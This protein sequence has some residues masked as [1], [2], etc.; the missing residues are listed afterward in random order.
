MATVADGG[1]RRERRRHAERPRRALRAAAS[2][3][4]RPAGASAASAHDGK[5]NFSGVW[6]ALNEA[7]WDLRGARSAPGNGDADR[8]STIT[9]TPAFRRRPSSRSVPR[10][11]FRRRLAS[12]R[13]TDRFRTSQKRR[14]QRR[15]TAST[16][17]I[18]IPNSSATCPALRGRCTAVSVRD[19]PGHQQGADDLRV[20]ERGAAI[21]LE[22]GRRSARGY[23]DGPLGRPLGRRH[24]GRRT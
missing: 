20:L 7:N 19:H 12:C 15:R 1:R 8:A 23:L 11:A 22:Q 4:A 16:G 9:S 17:S 10:P 3:A 2:R 14:R 24:V 13:T 6:Q 21:H 5:P 18:A